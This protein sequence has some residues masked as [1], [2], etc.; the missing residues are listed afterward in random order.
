MEIWKLRNSQLCLPTLEIKEVTQEVAEE[1]VVEEAEVVSGHQDCVMEEVAA[2]IV[3][4][5]TQQIQAFISQPSVGTSFGDILDV[6]R[7]TIE[8]NQ[9]W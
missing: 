1:V 8:E 5:E 9:S 6:L 7:M 2:Q 4:S 3:T